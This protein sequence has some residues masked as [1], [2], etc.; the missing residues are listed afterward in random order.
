M[1]TSLRLR[2]YL[3]CFLLIA[4]MM[5]IVDLARAIPI[6][7]LIL[8]EAILCAAAAAVMTSIFSGAI[9]WRIERLR[10][11]T[12]NLLEASEPGLL[13]PEEDDTSRALNQSLRR[14]A[15]RIFE[16]VERLSQESHRLDAILKSMGEGVLAV[17]RQMHVQFANLA[18]ERAMG[19]TSPVA[20]D[21]PVVDVVREPAFLSLISDVISTGVPATRR[22]QF[23]G[24]GAIF[25]AHASPYAV[26]PHGGALV[27]LHDITDIE[28]L[29]RIRRDFVANVSHELK[30]PLA[31]IRGYAETLLGGA[32]DDAT[33]NRRFVEIIQAQAIRLNNI[34]TDL[35]TLSDLESGKPDA[36]PGAVSVEDAVDTALATVETEARVRGVKLIRGAVCDALVTGHAI[37]L[38]QALVNLLDNAVKF[39]KPDGEVRIEAG[40]KD[41]R[42]VISIADTGAGIPSSD[43][44]RIFE[45]FYRVDR[46]RSREVGGTGLGLSIVKHVVERM[47]GTIAVESR[48]GEGSTFT[49]SLPARPGTGETESRAA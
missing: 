14:M 48:L 13:L 26:A 4:C 23:S 34:A 42:V 45:R 30:T 3:T 32:L 38:E 35:L 1:F 33:H 37:R 21:T 31:A 40:P 16:L 47:D 46:A 27:I 36:E 8:I 6:V 11:F 7:V 20:R 12:D 5:A 18:L 41:G 10:S 28:R 19:L 25:Q 44:S 39:N 9:A 15:A 24:R 49:I 43:V 2:L 22:L 17:D 29:E